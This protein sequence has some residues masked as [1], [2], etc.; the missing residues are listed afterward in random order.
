MTTDD[1][2]KQKLERAAT[3]YLECGTL[4]AT[5]KRLRIGEKTV[6]RWAD[7]PTFREYVL[8]AQRDA[9]QNA[10]GRLSY[11]GAEAVDVLVD[12]MR[13]TKVP[14]GVRVRAASQILGS[15]IT[16]TEFATLESR[17]AAL[18]NAHEDPYTN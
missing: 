15:L 10:V 8:L 3:A 13:N 2:V 17:I 12:V 18:E 1:R 11:A 6:R 4:K 16:I 5:A 9:V 7:T 14:P